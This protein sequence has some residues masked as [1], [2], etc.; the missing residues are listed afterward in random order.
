MVG[1]FDFGGFRA[2]FHGMFPEVKI[3]GDEVS[4]RLNSVDVGDVDASLG[5]PDLGFADFLNLISAAAAERLEAMGERAASVK[6]ARFGNV[7]K[8]YSP[9]YISNYCVNECVYCG[10]N[11]ASK[12]RRRR[13]TLDELDAELEAIS[14]FGIDS[15]LLVSGEDPAITLDYL[16]EAAE[17][18][19]R[20]F[21]YVAVEIYPLDENGYSTLHHAGV[22]GLTLYQET[23]ER[24]TY[25]RLHLSGPKADY[26]A[27]LGSIEA[28]ARAGMRVL[29]LGVLLGL[30]DWRLEAVSLAAHASWL[31]RRYWRTAIQFSFPRI[32]PANDSFDIPAAVSE[33]E[34]E[35]MVLAFRLFFP[36]AE[37]SISTRESREFRDRMAVSAATSLSAASRVVPGGYSE[38]ASGDL[39]Q[40]SLRDTRTVDEM[41]GDL[42]A[43]GLDVAFKDWDRTL[44]GA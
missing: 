1:G 33:S 40:F 25:E 7:A 9:L 32:T 43:L 39:G 4:R 38:Q 3:S 12:A 6:R 36:D 15:I 16:R 2:T 20:R 8:L 11:A 27:R 22:D 42:R 26:D 18:A 41:A 10:F 14:D 37:V 17:M 13:L 31:K 44:M 35:Q 30:A 5:S 21:S 24:D 29:G 19:R 23:Y 28:G 34:L